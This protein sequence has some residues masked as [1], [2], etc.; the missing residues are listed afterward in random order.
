VF[1]RGL[2]ILCAMAAVA[3]L[4]G[5]AAISFAPNRAF[6]NSPGVQTS[7]TPG[8]DPD[9]YACNQPGYIDFENF[10]DGY[11]LSST[12]IQGVQFTTT[13]GYTW[14]VGDFATGPYNGKYPN[15]AYTSQGTK[16]AWLGENEGSGRI[17]FVDGPASNF[18][19]LVS[20]NTPVQVDAYDSSNNRL[21]TAGPVSPNIN[22]GEMDSL[23]V[24]ST[25]ANIAYVMVH[26]SGNFF[27]VDS[28]C[29]NAASVPTGG[30]V[31]VGTPPGGDLTGG[32]SPSEPGGVGERR[33]GRTRHRSDRSGDRDPA[34]VHPNLRLHRGAG[35]L[36]VELAGQLWTGP[37]GGLVRQLGH[38]DRLQ[39][40]YRRGHGDRGE[41]RPSDLPVL[42]HR[43]HRT[44]L[45]PPGLLGAGLLPHGPAH[46]EF[47]RIQPAAGTIDR[48]TSMG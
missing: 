48:R 24:T 33:S 20:A 7:D 37:G 45:V 3:A 9:T 15:G 31:P 17:D 40:G 10:S 16:W 29:T 18:S 32:N 34:A 25:S 5:G 13:N 11:D 42:R 22:T 38:E 30:V 27:L 1:A 8:I 2:P 35:W 26:D 44:R 43:G 21:G 19:L 39:L 46:A 36:G 12:A 28:V 14:V 23:A 41:R 6:A 47:V 4:L